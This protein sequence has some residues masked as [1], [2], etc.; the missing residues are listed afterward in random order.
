MPTKLIIEPVG[1]LFVWMQERN[2]DSIQLFATVFAFSKNKSYFIQLSLN[3]SYFI[4][5]F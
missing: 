1:D 2:F 3:K 5:F 4:Q